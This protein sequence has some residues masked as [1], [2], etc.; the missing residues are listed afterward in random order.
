MNDS[1]G[2]LAVRTV[3]SAVEVEVLGK[4][5]LK[6]DMPDG[7]RE[8]RGVFVTL[9][10]HPGGELRGC[11]GYPE[12]MF[13]LGRG[14]IKAAQGACHDPR[15]PPLRSE[16]L[17]S[18]L[19]E[20]SVLTP[21]HEILVDRKDLPGAIRVGRD[22]LIVEMGPFRGLLLPQVPVE[23]DWDEESFLCHTCMKAGLTPDSWLDPQ[24]RIF[25]FQGE[26][27][28]EKEPGGGVIRKVLE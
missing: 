20:V 21:P 12:P 23:W 25:S 7:F 17:D 1:E 28:S 5:P 24:T 15:F 4:E 13:S 2:E 27:F 3:R 22:G 6:L 10:T 14:L 16:E 18:V 26:I 19:V 11:I 8:K 9:N